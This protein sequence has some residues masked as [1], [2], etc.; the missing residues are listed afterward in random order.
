[1]TGGLYDLSGD[2]TGSPQL[3]LGVYGTGELSNL[4]SAFSFTRTEPI[5]GIIS[6]G[7]LG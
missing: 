4:R 2:L 5:S 1:M 3:R 6:L 7:V